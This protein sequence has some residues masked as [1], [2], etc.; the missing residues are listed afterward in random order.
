[1]KAALG[2]LSFVKF[3]C[4]DVWGGW[5]FGFFL[6]LL[7]SSSPSCSALGAL[8]WLCACWLSCSGIAL[9][10]GQ[11]SLWLPGVA[12]PCCAW[13]FSL[14]SCSFAVIWKAQTGKG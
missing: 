1:M 3:Q 6:H 7:P 12:L 14:S 9:C 11:R 10:N 2:L 5:V 4:G 13:I 8:A